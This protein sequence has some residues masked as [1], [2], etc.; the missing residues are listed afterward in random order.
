MT[1]AAEVINV[2]EPS[3]FEEAVSSNQIKKWLEA[4]KKEIQTLR[5]DILGLYELFNEGRC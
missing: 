4:M 1:V 5:E 2:K 3:D